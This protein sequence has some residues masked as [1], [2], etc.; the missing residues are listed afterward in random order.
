MHYWRLLPDA[1]LRPWIHCYWWVEPHPEYQA[2]AARDCGSP[3]LLIPDGHSELVFRF[4][5]EIHTLATLMRQ[6]R[7]RENELRHRRPFEVRADSE[8]RRAAVRGRQTGSARVAGAATHATDRLPRQ[9]GG[10]R[11]LGSRALLELEDEVANLRRRP[12]CRSSRPVFPARLADELR[13]DSAIQHC[14]NGSRYAWRPAHP[15]VGAQTRPRCPNPRT[16]LRCPHG[17]DAQ[18]IRTRRTFQAQLPLE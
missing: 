7:A 16:A 1:R 15:R 2:D 11:E 9:H 6:T 13:D 12:G 10:L 8:P 17:H 3:D 4:A 5:G 18:A 14:S